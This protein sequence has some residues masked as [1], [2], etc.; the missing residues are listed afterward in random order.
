MVGKVGGGYGFDDE[1][2]TAVH[3]LSN[4]QSNTKIRQSLETL[5]S[6]IR[7]IENTMNSIKNQVSEI[8]REVQQNRY[9]RKRFCCPSLLREL[10][11]IFSLHS[12]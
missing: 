9:N 8:V 7:D 1:I 6:R 2:D 12:G 11:N 3:I 10:F 4:I 5:S